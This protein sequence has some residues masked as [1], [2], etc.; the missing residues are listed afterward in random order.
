MG[1][2]S[3]STN[4]YVLN[5]NMKNN[6]IMIV[7]FKGDRNYYNFQALNS[8]F[9]VLAYDK[10]FSSLE[11]KKNSF[12]SFQNEIEQSLSPRTLKLTYTIQK[13]YWILKILKEAK[14]IEWPSLRIILRRVFQII[15]I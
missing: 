3:S 13:D 14:I 2:L 1:V 15:I 12:H 9:F 7:L 4:N 10:N 6:Y 5:F 11:K 8:K